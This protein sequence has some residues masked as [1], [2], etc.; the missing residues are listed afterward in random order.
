MTTASAI[1]HDLQA[2]ALAELDRY[3][4][5]YWSH[6]SYT[7]EDM[8]PSAVRG[9]LES[10]KPCNCTYPPHDG[11]TFERDRQPHT[12]S[13]SLRGHPHGFGAGYGRGD[14]AWWRAVCAGLEAKGL[15]AANQGAPQLN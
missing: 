9:Y 15:T 5:R 6:R 11:H 13:F 3:L 2:Q 7:H 1:P 10:V 12:H 8:R 4:A 14:F